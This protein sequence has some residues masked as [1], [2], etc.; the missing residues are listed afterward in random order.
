MILFGDVCFQF[1]DQMLTICMNILN[2][3]HKH[4]EDPAA[5][6]AARSD[7]TYVSRVI[8]AM[9]KLTQLFSLDLQ[10]WFRVL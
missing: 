8:S 4:E 7:A 1:E 9:V 3:N 2:L 5:D 6:V 10:S